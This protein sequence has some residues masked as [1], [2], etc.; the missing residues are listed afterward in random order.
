MYPNRHPYQTHHF[1][2]MLGRLPQPHRHSSGYCRLNQARHPLLQHTDCRLLCK[3]YRNQN[4]RPYRD[5]DRP[6]R[7]PDCRDDRCRVDYHL[8]KKR[9]SLNLCFR[10]MFRSLHNRPLHLHRHRSHKALLSRSNMQ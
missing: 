6:C 3:A 9:M 4:Y 10:D 7:R 2:L 1:R 5:F 8:T